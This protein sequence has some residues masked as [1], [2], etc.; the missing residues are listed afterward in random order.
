MAKMGRPTDA[1]KHR[2]KQILESSNAYRRYTQI[3]A[4]TGKDDVFLK[5]FEMA[6]DRAYGKAQ[7]FLDME[8]NDVSGRPTK[9]ELDEA[10]RSASDHPSGNGLEKTE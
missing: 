10:L 6:H 3:L 7:Q 5:A 1:L 8:L 9:E 2:F 4:K